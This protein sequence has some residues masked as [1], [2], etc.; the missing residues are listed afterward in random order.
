MDEEWVDH[1]AA[2]GGVALTRALLAQSSY[3]RCAELTGVAAPEAGE[4]GRPL[5]LD[6]GVLE[7]AS[8]GAAASLEAAEAAAAGYTPVSSSEGR[9]ASLRWLA[10]SM[11]WDQESPGSGMNL[12]SN[13]L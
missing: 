1:S 10:R 4:V 2:S 3:T 6:L 13:H 9:S 11:R 5:E 7:V 12:F 8:G